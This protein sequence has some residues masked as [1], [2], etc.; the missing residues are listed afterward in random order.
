MVPMKRVAQFG[1]NSAP[2]NCVATCLSRVSSFCQTP[3]LALPIGRRVLDEHDDAPSPDG[4]YGLSREQESRALRRAVVKE[5]AAHTD[6]VWFVGFGSPMHFQ[7][8]LLYYALCAESGKCELRVDRRPLVQC[9]KRRSGKCQLRPDS[10]R[11]APGGCT[12]PPITR[13]GGALTANIGSFRGHRS[14]G[15]VGCWILAMAFE[16]GRYS[17]LS[18]KPLESRAA[19]VSAVHF[20]AVIVP[21]NGSMHGTPPTDS[22]R[23]TLGPVG[24]RELS[25]RLPTST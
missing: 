13:T 2:A 4:G 25:A 24:A 12:S 21:A 14:V 19:F 17:W 23:G 6:C 3:D 5:L 11:P 22:L 16:R 15:Q 9:P 1:C 10:Q 8:T 7:T 20:T 18:G